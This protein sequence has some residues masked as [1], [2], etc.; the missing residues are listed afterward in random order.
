M[1][2]PIRRLRV[3]PRL[4]YAIALARRAG[5]LA[6]LDGGRM[7]YDLQLVTLANAVLRQ[8]DRQEAMQARKTARLARLPKRPTMV[9][10]VAVRLE[11]RRRA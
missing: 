1:L 5:Q 6:A 11:R 8:L 3:T 9:G 10:V 7:V 2:T 4:R